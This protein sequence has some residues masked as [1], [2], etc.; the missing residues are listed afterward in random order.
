[1]NDNPLISV[2]IP[3]YNVKKYI[4][5]CILSVE[6][7]SYSNLEI[8]IINDGST[9]GSGE[10]CDKMASFDTRI[11]VIH[12]EN[13]GLSSARNRG[14]SNARGEF[15][16][17]IDSDDYIHFDMISLLFGCLK[18]NR[19]LLACCD[20]TSLEE[21]KINHQVNPITLQQD[22]AI[23]MILDHKG[24]KCYAWNKLYKKD[25][26]T[27]IKFPEGKAYEDI[28]TTY[29]LFK[30]VNFIMYIKQPLYHY[31]LRENSIT[32]KNFSDSNYDLVNAINYLVG[33]VKKNYSNLYFRV[34]TG[35]MNYYLCFFNSAILSCVYVKNEEYQF[36]KIV[37]ENLLNLIFCKNV[38][39]VKKNEIIALCYIPA[40]YKWV[41]YLAHKRVLLRR[42]IQI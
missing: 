26:F 8:I 32:N 1:M 36:K 9:D 20:F 28:I 31:T 12:Q 34:I 3:V 11:R 37:K 23:S 41:F 27:N 29:N 13:R 33:D 4:K 30:E 19:G 38:P 42:K 2:I 22:E 6:K 15:I 25:L 21:F 5:K 40:V 7:Q 18:E 39:F 16:S 24:F 14:L 35:Y 10:I 17:F